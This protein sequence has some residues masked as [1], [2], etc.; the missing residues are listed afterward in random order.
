[1]ERPLKILIFKLSPI[2]DTVMFLPVV[3]ELRRIYPEIRVTLCTTPALEPFFRPFLDPRDIW[4]E[5]RV[6]IQKAWRSPALLL[7]WI[8][9]VRK[10]RPDAVL[11][12]FDQSSIARLL[13]VASGATKRIG[14]SGA[15]V[16]WRGGLTHEVGI[17]PCDALANWDWE[18]ARVLLDERWP[19]RPPAPE[20]GFPRARTTGGC[21][22]VIIHPGASREYQ[23][24]ETPRYV[25]LAERLSSTCDVTWIQ[26]PGGPAEAPQPPSICWKARDL[27][28]FARLAAAADLFVGNHS[29]PFHIA[30]AIGTPCVIP[31]G[32][33]LPVCD[34]PW[35]NNSILRRTG[36]SCMPCDKLVASPNR[37]LNSETPMACLNYWT[38]DAVEKICRERLRAVEV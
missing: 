21:P 19:A 7:R 25:E 11:L 6:R 34:P 9:R 33:S 10:L 12:S 32:P 36:L 17:R 14:G 31:T 18:M 35:G 23:L 4:V 24:W 27:S 38:V 13:A 15:T 3:Q 1:M 16:R 37:C 22:K 2:G 5:E 30:A 28:D 20:L 26:F 8:L 29:G